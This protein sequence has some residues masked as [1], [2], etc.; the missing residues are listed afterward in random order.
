[1]Y[2]LPEKKKRG[3]GGG[4]GGEEKKK[5]KKA[6]ATTTKKPHISDVLEGKH[7]HVTTKTTQRHTYTEPASGI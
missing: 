6:A 4:G 3:G 7:T 5:R 2:V 1:M